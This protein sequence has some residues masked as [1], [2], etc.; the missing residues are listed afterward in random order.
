MNLLYQQTDFPIFQNR[1]YDTA[2]EAKGCPKGD[3]ELVED[4]QTGLVLQYLRQMIKTGK[5]E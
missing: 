4:L 3:I 5:S 2:E 1:M